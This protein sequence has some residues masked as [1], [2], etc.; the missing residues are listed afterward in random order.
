MDARRERLLGRGRRS[1]VPNR[2]EL[3]ARYGYDVKYASTRS[4]FNVAV[5]GHAVVRHTIDRMRRRVDC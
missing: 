2:P 3:V 1:S 4:G 5:S